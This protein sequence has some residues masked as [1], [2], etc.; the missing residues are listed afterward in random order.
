MLDLD[1]GDRPC[2]NPGLR[3]QTSDTPILGLAAAVR[4]RRVVE[5][6]AEAIGGG[7]HLLIL[8]CVEVNTG[9]EIARDCL[10]AE[11]SSRDGG[12]R[13]LLAETCLVACFLCSS[14]RVA[15]IKLAARD[16]DFQLFLLAHQRRGLMFVGAG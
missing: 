10:L 16:K 4:R 7:F 6:L 13:S 1:K 9:K 14:L 3:M 2:L 12:V 15:S 5:H 11:R 8:W